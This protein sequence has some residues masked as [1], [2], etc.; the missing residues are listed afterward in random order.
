EAASAAA[1][2][3]I[4][5]VTVGFGTQRGATIP[6]PVNGRTVQ[7]RDRQGEIVVTR[8]T[9]GPLQA[10][11]EASGGTFVAAPET[12]KAGRVRAAL[13]NLRTQARTVDAGSSRQPRFQLFLLP[14]FLLV[15][16][17]AWLIDSRRPRQAR[18]RFTTAPLHAARTSTAAI[19]ALPPLLPL[20]VPAPP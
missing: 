7:K 14:V 5:V 2:A 20:L 12:D 13:R 8:Y 19:T 3:G 17:D 15:V 10:A 4:A 18:R 11:A 6:E 16:L 9:P 1:E